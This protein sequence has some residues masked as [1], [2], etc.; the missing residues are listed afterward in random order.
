MPGIYFTVTCKFKHAIYFACYTCATTKLIEFSLIVQTS[1]N[2]I[3]NDL[4]K[5]DES[6]E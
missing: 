4:E 3:E 6:R 2:K 1:Y 5:Q